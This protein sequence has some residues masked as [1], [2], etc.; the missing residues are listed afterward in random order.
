MGARSHHHH[1]RGGHHHPEPHPELLFLAAPQQVH[2][3]HHVREDGLPRDGQRLD[4]GLPQDSLPPPEIRA[5]GVPYGAA[6][7]HGAREPAWREQPGRPQGDDA[8]GGARAARDHHAREQLHAPPHVLPLLRGFRDGGDDGG[9]QFVAVE[10]GPR[11]RRD[12][13]AED[14]DQAPPCP[15]RAQAINSSPQP[16]H[17]GAEES[18]SQRPAQ[19]RPR[20]ARGRGGPQSG[21]PLVPPDV[22]PCRR[23]QGARSR[24]LLAAEHGEPR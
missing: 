15:T 12:D 21:P 3:D 16:P 18:Q 6:I 8:R 1:A 20:R 2:R 7:E 5:G 24:R 9:Q 4:L 22:R 23:V 11:P 10:R 14:N 19:Q 13:A 17:V